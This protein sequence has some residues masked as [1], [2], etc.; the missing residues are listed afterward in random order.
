[1]DFL[2]TPRYFKRASNPRR[3]RIRSAIDLFS[4]AGGLAE[5]FRQAGFTILSGTDTNAAAGATFR[6]NFPEASFFHT[7]VSKLSGEALLEDAG[8]KPGELDCL[9]GGPP[10]QSFSYNNHQRSDE[11]HRATLFRGYL[12]L[13]KELKP[14]CLVM[15]NV[16]GILTIGNGAIV[17]E[18]VLSLA[19]LGYTCEARILYS[20]DFGVPQERR[21]V[22]F[23]ASRLTDRMGELFPS[24]SHG[25]RSKPSVEANPFVHRWA[26]RKGQRTRRF[27]TVWSA[28]GDLPLLRNGEGEEERDY[29]RDPR[30]PFQRRMRDYGRRASL[31]NHVAPRLSEEMLDRIRHVPEGGSWRDIPRR[32]LPSGMKRAELTDHTKRYGRLKKRGLCCTILTKCDPHWGS[33]IHPTNDRAITVREA[34]RLQSFHD[35]FRFLGFRSQQFE[36]VGN[37]VPPLMAAAL[38]RSARRHLLKCSR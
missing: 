6:W 18:I 7:A 15:E 26:L 37:A 21:R 16:P 27:V 2:K 35:R 20:E 33:Y 1:M 28:I 30:G 36:Q 29:T 38:A 4:G 9:I 3:R 23:V 5:G 14:K 34:A 10:C 31:Y 32:L 19:K 25:P 22:F 17:E 24:G 12:R 8:L 13:V 11:D